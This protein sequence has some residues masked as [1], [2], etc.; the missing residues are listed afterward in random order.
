M[1]EN[2]IAASPPKKPIFVVDPAVA[3]CELDAFNGVMR[4][5]PQGS[6]FR[7]FAPAL[8]GIEELL[9]SLETPLAI[10]IFGSSASVYDGLPW[11]DEFHQ[12]VREQVTAK[13][14]T[15]GLC[16]GHQLLAALFG[17]KVG[18]GFDGEKKRGFRSFEI[19]RNCRLPLRNF[20]GA[21]VVS[22]K[23]VVLDSGVL[24]IIAESDS[25]VC[26]GVEH[27][28]LPAWGFQAHVEATAGFLRNRGMPPANSLDDF[29]FGHEV[30][31]AFLKYA[32]K[33]ARHNET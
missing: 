1:S 18:L 24:E 10:I 29:A 21:C 32:F 33:Q 7:Y 13:V 5:A 2:T 12:W 9:E 17:G 16:Y 31:D 15:L 4:R 22:H 30:V 6:T 28:R 8:F 19:S 25:V 3:H 27:P 26:E 14:P 11:Q 23:E 20:R